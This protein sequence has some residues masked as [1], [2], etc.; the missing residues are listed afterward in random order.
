MIAPRFDHATKAIAR[1]G[2]SRRNALRAL[3]GTGI[4]AALSTGVGQGQRNVAAQSSKTCCIYLNQDET[5]GNY[6]VA[7]RVCPRS[8]SCPSL[9]FD[10]REDVDV[11]D[12]SQCPAYP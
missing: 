6:G 5:S 3:T 2:L 12:C 7:A 8:S 1:S 10:Q 11:D 9:P 4:A